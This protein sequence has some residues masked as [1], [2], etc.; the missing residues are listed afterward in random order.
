MKRPRGTLIP[1]LLILVVAFALRTYRLE[2]QSLWGDEAWSVFFAQQGWL[3]MLDWLI[4]DRHLPLYFALLKLWLP[5]AGTSEFALRFLS[6]FFS[7]ISMALLFTLAKRLLGSRAGI[8]SMLFLAFSAFDLYLAQEARMYT[9]LAFLIL[10]ST[11]LLLRASEGGRYVLPILVLVDVAALYTH[12]FALFS[13]GAQAIFAVISARRV[14]AAQGLALVSYLPW[15]LAV[16]FSSRPQGNLDLSRLQPVQLWGVAL[17]TGRA[18]AVGLTQESG[19][20]MVI[21]GLLLPFL[22][23]GVIWLGRERREGYLV[24]LLLIVPLLGAM[25][26]LAYVPYFFPRYLFFILWAYILLLAAGLAAVGRW[27]RAWALIPL[28]LF[29]AANASSVTNLYTQDY[30][31]KSG[32]RSMIAYLKSHMSEGELIVLNAHNQVP[33]FSY[34]S[35]GLP[36]RV[37]QPSGDLDVGKELEE[38]ARGRPGLWLVMLGNVTFY[39][40]QR[41]VEGWLAR[42]AYFGQWKGF[43]DVS[44]AYF[45]LASVGEGLYQPQEAFYGGQIEMNGYRLSAH[46]VRPGESLRLSLFW[47]AK[48][49][50]D[51]DYTV[52]VH[53]LDGQM[54][55]VAGVDSQPQLGLFPTRSW[56]LEQVVEDRYALRVPLEAK[57]GP[58]YVEVGL[59]WG[60]GERLPL[61]G[62]SGSSVVLGPVEVW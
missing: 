4:T 60:G 11:Y 18:L 46:R 7:L 62:V 23:T 3:P 25:A 26:S 19:Y 14:L 47:R 33:L 6:V 1:C 30:Y 41:E 32:Y 20:S 40:P 37:V 5:L 2:M 50:I 8:V 49:A 59:Y 24:V 45:A 17:T 13:V 51:R 27:H 42:Q 15:L 12:Y 34:Y 35:G 38:A 21:A 28:T 16:T 29:L 39:D 43:G 52:F 56:R 61:E 58:Y 48:D 57:P 55:Q 31:R 36:Y 22:L 44:L 10:L 54:V 53:L 9:L